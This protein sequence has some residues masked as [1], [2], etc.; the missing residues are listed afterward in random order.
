MY[1][2]SNLSMSIWLGIHPTVIDMAKFRLL[3]GFSLLL[4]LSL[5]QVSITTAEVTIGTFEIKKGNF[6]V[7]L[8][9]YGAIVISVILPDSKGNLADVALGYDI[10]A[11]YANDTANF[12]AIV[13]RVANR[14]AG[15]Q[16]TLDGKTYKLIA[17]DGKNT[18]HG[19]AFLDLAAGKFPSITFAYHSFDG[20]EGKLFLPPGFF[21]TI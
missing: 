5:L 4:A 18:L 7:K 9:N 2:G 15:A 10:A 11:Q 3:L 16:F 13:G 21:A 12:G 20:E 8:T 19:I 1:C 6:S 17:N 14:I